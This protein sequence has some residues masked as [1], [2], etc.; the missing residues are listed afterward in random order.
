MEEKKKKV[1]GIK[2]DT[3]S[4][5]LKGFLVENTEWPHSDEVARL[6]AR[7]VSGAYLVNV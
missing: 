7:G 2:S 6:R 1:D 4:E 3:W 5:I